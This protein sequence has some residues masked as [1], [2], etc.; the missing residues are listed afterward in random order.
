MAFRFQMV[1]S[2]D[3]SKKKPEY[4]S[5]CYMTKQFVERYELGREPPKSLIFDKNIKREHKEEN[6]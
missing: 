1:T 4:G 5:R 2:E 3:A 6:S